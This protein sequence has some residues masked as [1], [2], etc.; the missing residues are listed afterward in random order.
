ME[1]FGL[2]QFL[3]NLL[4]SQSDLG[5]AS[6]SQSADVSPKEPPSPPPKTEESL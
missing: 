5:E 1:P 6:P 3:Q 2:F 4:N